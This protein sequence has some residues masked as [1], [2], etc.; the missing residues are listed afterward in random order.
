MI[1]LD[2]ERFEKT[3]SFNSIKRNILKSQGQAQFF[4]TQLQPPWNDKIC[5]KLKVP[6]MVVDN[7]HWGALECQFYPLVIALRI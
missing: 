7:L 3:T 5:S 1:S 2:K 4:V 6:H